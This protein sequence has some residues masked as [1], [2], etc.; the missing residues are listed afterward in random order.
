[1]ESGAIDPAEI[2]T[3]T[4]PLADA[5]EAY[6]AFDR[7]ESGWIKV[8]AQAQREGARSRL[9]QLPM[10]RVSGQRSASGSMRLRTE[11]PMK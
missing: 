4:E 10:L 7:R 11:T 6:K 3:Q 2:L 1:M 8:E 5:I 9:S